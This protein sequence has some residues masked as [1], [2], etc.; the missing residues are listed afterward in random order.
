MPGAFA[1]LLDSGKGC[2][3]CG[4]AGRQALGMAGR[5]I[6][7]PLAPRPTHFPG[8]GQDRDLAVHERRPEPGRHLGLQA[9]AGQARRQGAAGFDKNTGFFTAQVGPLM[10]SP[11]KFAQHGESGTWVSEIFPN[12]AEH[13]D[14][15][16]FIHSCFTETN[17]HSPALF[18]INTG[19]SRMGFPCVGL[20]GDLRPGNREP[21]P[22]GVRRDVRHARPRLA[23]GPRPELGRRASCRASTRGRRST[24]KGARSTTSTAAAQ[25]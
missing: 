19:F 24:P 14:D 22:A 17:N 8:R 13:V 1:S 15:M 21:E 6:V 5:Y 10:K 16:A 3:L 7:N 25:G 2:S 18:E 20:V 12:M 9:R 11:F 23:Q 4:I